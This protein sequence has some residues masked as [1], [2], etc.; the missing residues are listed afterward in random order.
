MGDVE[1]SRFVPKVPLSIAG[2][3]KRWNAV[4]IGASAG[5]GGALRTIL[6]LLPGD[7]ALPILIAQH[8][9]P[10]DNGGFAE[11]LARD[12]SLPVTSACDK[13]VIQAGHIYVAPANYHMLVERNGYIALTTDEKVNW[14]RPSID[15]LFESA[16]YAWREK[17]IALILSGANSDGTEGLRTIKK[18]GGI[19]LAQDPGTTEYPA[20]PWSAINAGVVDEIL[21]LHEIGQRL[22]ELV[23]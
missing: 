5:G 18:L 22:T 16:A 13:Q 4:A 12:V 9:H 10:D 15:V 14:S 8:L 7:Y 20:M 3:A 23:G 17:L 21:T 19:A 2:A 11:N 6:S 1:H